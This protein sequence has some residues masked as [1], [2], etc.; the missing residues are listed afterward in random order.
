MTNPEWPAWDDEKGYPHINAEAQLKA[1]LGEETGK[2]IRE[3]MLKHLRT[4]ASLLKPANDQPQDSPLE[5][6]PGA[7]DSLGGPETKA[8]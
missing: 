3:E 2:M 7:E 8:T 5:S 1:R 4:R 6:A